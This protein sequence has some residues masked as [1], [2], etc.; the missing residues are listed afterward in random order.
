MVLKGHSRRGNA[1]VLVEHE[2]VPRGQKR[3]GES[4]H[5][6]GV[7]DV[8]NQTDVDALVDDEDR[9]LDP[10]AAVDPEGDAMPAGRQRHVDVGIEHPAA[11]AADRSRGAAG[12]DRDLDVGHMHAGEAAPA[13]DAAELVLRRARLRRTPEHDTAEHPD[14]APSAIA[15]ERH[16]RGD[17]PAPTSPALPQA[18]HRILDPRGEVERFCSG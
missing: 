17:Q 16:D 6:D 9:R 18:L 4:G 12:A 5:H 8:G 3:P 10:G 2:G 15:R 1:C 14:P 13:A 7:V 11:V